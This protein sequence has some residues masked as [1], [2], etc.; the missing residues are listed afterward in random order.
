MFSTHL[1][2]ISQIGNLPQVGVNIKNI[3]NHQLVIC[4]YQIFQKVSRSAC[5]ASVSPPQKKNQK[6]KQVQGARNWVLVPLMVQKSGIHQLRLVVY[7]FIYRVLRPSQMALGFLVAINSSISSPFL[8]P[9]PTGSRSGEADGVGR[10]WGWSQ[11]AL[12]PAWQIQ[13]IKF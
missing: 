7:L 2:N 5:L 8:L 9:N 12:A 6:K 1:K 3:W 4:S 10:W 11:G 13:L